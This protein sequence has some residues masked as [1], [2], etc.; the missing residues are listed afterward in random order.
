MTGKIK[1]LSVRSPSGVITADNGLNLYF[2]A[3]AVWP[4]RGAGLAI[5]Q[6]VSFD[7]EGSQPPMAVNVRSMPQHEPARRPSK[8]HSDV[9]HFQYVGFQHIGSVRAYRFNRVTQ[10]EETR[11]FVV[12]ADLALFAKYHVAIQ[13]GPALCL[14]LLLSAAVDIAGASAE[15]SQSLTDQDM[16]AHLAR[17]PV[18]AARSGPKR[19]RVISGVSS[20]A[21]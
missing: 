9:T 18:P 11:Q 2:D 14:H 17:R 16:V 19:N 4:D 8:G 7:L 13:E 12:N 10:G 5:G 1:S 3:W 15:P 20:A 21:V 6:I